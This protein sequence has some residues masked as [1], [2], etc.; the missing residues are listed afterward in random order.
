VYPR[1]AA[2]LR[3]TLE[4]YLEARSLERQANGTFKIEEKDE[5]ETRN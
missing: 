1:A 2:R 4:Q 5:N 3:M